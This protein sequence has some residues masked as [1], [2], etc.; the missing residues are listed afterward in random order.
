MVQED[1]KLNLYEYIAV[2]VEDLCIAPH[3]PKEFIKILRSKYQLKLKGDGPL[4]YHLGS[5]Y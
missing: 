4:T 1:S 5:N 2:Y 3:D